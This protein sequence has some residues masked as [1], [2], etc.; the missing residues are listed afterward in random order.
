MIKQI[1]I[2]PMFAVLFLGFATQLMD[3]AESTSE[4]TLDFTYDMQQAVDCATRGVDMRE[5]SPGIYSHDF[6]KEIKQ[7]VDA[8]KEFL[9]KIRNAAEK[10]NL[11]ITERDG[12]IIIEK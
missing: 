4:K 9:E 3:I 10:S 2:Y 6:D 12:V 11:T 5:C 1:I 8:N 7:T